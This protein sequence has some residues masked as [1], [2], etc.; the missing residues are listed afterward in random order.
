[1]KQ[2]FLSSAAVVAAILVQTGPSEAIIGGTTRTGRFPYFVSLADAN[3]DHQCGGTLIAA[4]MVAT[5]ASCA[6]A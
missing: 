4:D 2:F 5:A 3:G 1:M 6:S